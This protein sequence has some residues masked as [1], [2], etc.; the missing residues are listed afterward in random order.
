MCKKIVQKCIAFFC[1]L[2]MLLW[3]MAGFSISTALATEKTVSLTL[4]CQMDDTIL[5]DMQWS[6]Y[7]VGE[8]IGNNSYRLE[9]DFSK[10][11][12]SMKNLTDT[13]LQDAADTLENYA[14]LDQIKPQQTGATDETGKLHAD[15]L[16]EGLYLLSGAKKMI[17]FREYIP[18]AI[19]VELYQND[20]EL[21]FTVYP[22]YRVQDT[23]SGVTARFIVQKVWMNDDSQLENRSTQLKVAIYQ[24]AQFYEE[25]ILSEENDWTYMWNGDTDFDW[26][27][28]EVDVPENYTVVYRANEQQY[29]IVNTFDS[30]QPPTE[31]STSTTIPVLTTTLPS[32]TGQTSQSTLTIVQTGT[33]SSSDR[34]S[35]SGSKLPQTGQLWWPVPLL[36]GGGLICIVIGWRIGRKK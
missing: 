23:L 33:P 12:V 6:I 15:G 32:T 2:G 5:S 20:T 35:G 8:R 30:E 9:D 1:V 31:T 7:R 27:V 4:I 24:D 3:I 11:R 10:Y 18:S 13:A 19:L 14:I 28:K 25:V 26:R 17:G 36:A 34:T 21:D 29:L 16:K 22:K